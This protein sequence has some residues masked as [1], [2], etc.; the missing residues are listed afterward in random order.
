MLWKRKKKMWVHLGEGIDLDKPNK[1]IPVGFD[2]KYR[3][4]HFWCFGTTRAG[5][6]KVIAGNVEE[7]IKK[8]H[9]VIVIDP[10]GD[11]ELFGSIVQAAF[12]TGR[13]SDLMLVCP[14][15]PEYSAT[16]DPLASYYMTEELV[17]HITAGV[18]VGK[19]PYYYGVAY[20]VALLVVQSLLMLARLSNQE[21]SFNLNDIKNHISHEALAELKERLDMLDQPEETGQLSADLG[22]IL[23]SSS[24]F[25]SKVSSSLRTA[26]LELT[27]GNIGQIIGNAEHDQFI[28][29]LESG[30]RIIMVVQLGAMLTKRAAYSGGKVILSMLQAYVGRKYASGHIVDPPIC[31]HIDEAQAVLYHGIEELFAKAG[32]AGIYISGYCQSIS[33]LNAEIGQDRA[34]TILDCCNTKMFL[35]VNDTRTAQYVSTQLGEKKTFSPIISLGGGLSIRETEDTRITHTEV[36][37]LKK[38]QFFLT[39]YSGIYRGRTRDV[40]D[41]KKVIVFPEIE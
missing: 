28:D 10:K 9:S 39:T 26:L 4:G 7:D 41:P 35:K 5:K 12:D 19:D 27:S 6:T 24:E 22:N 18:S 2:E 20:E 1:I 3:T 37:N 14:V 15:F 30:K 21:P 33:Q 11:N 25:N 32:G 38:R 34:S 16:I 8:G 40:P 31:L 13:E 29:R 17:A 23:K 36:L